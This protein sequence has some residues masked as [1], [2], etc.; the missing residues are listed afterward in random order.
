MGDPQRVERFF[1][2]PTHGRLVM[3]EVLDD[4][5]HVTLDVV[6]NELRFGILVDEAN[7]IREVSGRVRA[8]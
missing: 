4:E 6:D 1:D 3:A 2:A 7:D 8:R 5:R